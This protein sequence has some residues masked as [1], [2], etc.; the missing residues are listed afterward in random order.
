FT[1]LDCGTSATCDEPGALELAAGQ[2][3]TQATDIYSLGS[4]LAWLLTG[5]SHLTVVE[6]PAALLSQTSAADPLRQTGNLTQ[7]AHHAPLRPAGLDELL[8]GMLSAEPIDRPSAT[9]V[10]WR[11]RAIRESIAPERV[12]GRPESADNLLATRDVPPA[13]PTLAATG[14]F[15]AKPE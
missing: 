5:R 14:D 15:A 4:L 6:E 7:S 3:A 10:T 1:G 11:L 12:T 13:K 8:R 9:E 2:A